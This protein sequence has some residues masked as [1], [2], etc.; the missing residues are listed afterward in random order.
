[1]RRRAFFKICRS[2]TPKCVRCGCDDFRLLEINH[3]I[4]CSEDARERRTRSGQNI[5]KCI[6]NGS[7]TV[8]DLEL[9]CRPCNAIHYLEHKLGGPLPIKVIWR[10]GEK[11]TDMDATDCHQEKIK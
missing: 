3:K 9:L 5:C 6:V 4:A 8:D 11:H 7:R 10:G 1:M 2:V